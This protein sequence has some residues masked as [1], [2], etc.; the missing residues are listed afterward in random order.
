MHASGFEESDANVALNRTKE[1]HFKTI[2]MIFDSQ[3]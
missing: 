3:V 1:I 2:P